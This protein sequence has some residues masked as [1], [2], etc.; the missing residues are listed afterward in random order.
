MNPYKPPHEPRPDR[1]PLW[2]RIGVLGYL[3]FVVF[4][5]VCI[6]LFGYEEWMSIGPFSF[7]TGR[8]PW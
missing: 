2:V 6:G 5:Q 4:D 1:P 3:A 7:G 8:W